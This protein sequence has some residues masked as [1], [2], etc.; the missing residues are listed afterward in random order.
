MNSTDNAKA[1]LN[2]LANKFA[3]VDVSSMLSK[4][5][6]DTG[7]KKP[8]ANW[9]FSNQMIMYM[10]GT[11]DARGYNQWPKVYRHV[12]KGAKA[13]YILAP[14]M[15]TKQEKDEKTNEI[16]KIPI[17]VGFEAVPVFAIEDTEGEPLMEY[18]PKELPPL[19]EL[20][21]KEDLTVEYTDSTNGANGSYCKQTNKIT[22]HTEA[23]DTFLHEL[24]HHYD[25][26][27]HKPKPGQDQT[28]E[29]VAQ[30][31]AATLY[32]M[33]TG[34]D[35]VDAYTWGYLASYVNS[36]DQETVISTCLKVIDRVGKAIQAIV[37]DAEELGIKQVSTE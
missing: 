8:S 19:Y 37:N 25:L 10:H 32:K 9:S 18:T 20:A 6:I 7:V 36:T 26:K 4:I 16:T 12:K 1:V 17:L 27:T 15:F 33:Y 13:I 24:I 5:M 31:G 30:L 3:D 14:R 23:K 22:L 11:M 21:K 29:I 34:K 35:D 28:Q 2:E